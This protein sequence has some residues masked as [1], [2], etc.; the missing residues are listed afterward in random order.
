MRYRLAEDAKPQLKLL[1][2]AT[3]IT[4]AL[5]FIPYTEWLVYPIRRAI[6]ARVVLYGLGGFIALMTLVFGFLVPLFN[7]FGGQVTLASIGF[8]TLVGAALAAGMLAIARF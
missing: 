8:T 6:S 4:I 1:L 5:W 2:L 7:I 3:A